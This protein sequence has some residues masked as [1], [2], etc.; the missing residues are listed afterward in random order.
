M[1]NQYFMYGILMSYTDYLNAN[2]FNSIDEALKEDEDIQGIFTGRS[3]DFIIVGKVLK[4]IDVNNTEPLIVPELAKIDEIAIANIIEEKYGF[5][6][7]FHYYFI[8]K[9]K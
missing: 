2:T 6:G 1:K 4:T 5:V 7:T 9:Y 3:G 8:K